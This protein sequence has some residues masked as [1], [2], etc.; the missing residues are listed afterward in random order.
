MLVLVN[1]LLQVQWP[2]HPSF[3][4]ASRSLYYVDHLLLSIL[5]F[6]LSLRLSFTPPS[7]HFA[8]I[9]V[10]SYWAGGWCRI[11]RDDLAD[12][13]QEV[14]TIALPPF[15]PYWGLPCVK[16]SGVYYLFLDSWLAHPSGQWCNVPCCE[17]LIY[18]SL[19]SFLPFPPSAV[20]VFT[21]TVLSWLCL[22][23]LSPC[24]CVPWPGCRYFGDKIGDV[25]TKEDLQLYRWLR[26]PDLKISHAVTHI[27]CSKMW[28]LTC[29]EMIYTPMMV[30]CTQ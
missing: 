17:M 26:N 23:E 28:H 14:M 12:F 8:P 19:L 25:F 24:D 21:S 3:I 9:F 29:F 5:P 13:N 2:I 22:H 16:Q 11:L 7:T 18:A 1:H 20:S 15:I 6:P 10:S 4:T 27:Y 30:L